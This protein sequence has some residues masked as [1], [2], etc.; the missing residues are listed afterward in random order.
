MRD[1]WNQIS[2][3]YQARQQIQTVSAHYGPLAPPESELQLL[4]DVSGLRI[5]ELGCGG[6]QT[7]IAFAQQGATVVG[8]DISDQQLRFA[9]TLAAQAGVAVA[10]VQGDI[11]VLPNFQAG[12]WD[13]IFST[14]TLQYVED[15]P[16]CLAECWRLLRHRGRL[17]FSLDH[18]LRDCFFDLEEDELAPYPVRNYF[19]NTP[20]RWRFPET[21]VTLHSHHL[22]LAQWIDQLSSRNFQ[23][24]R[25]VEPMPPPAVLDELWPLDSAYSTLRNIP[26]TVIFVAKK[27]FKEEL[28]LAEL[29]EAGFD[30]LSQR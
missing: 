18:P 7:S 3:S 4:G 26:Q 23:L 17:V 1:A 10:F 25:L 9:R 11:S 6:G 19:D 21:N 15:L 12:E 13:L 5:L 30:K 16:L 8:V 28:P 24:C 27:L 2:A 29:V 14:Y 22:T 20:L